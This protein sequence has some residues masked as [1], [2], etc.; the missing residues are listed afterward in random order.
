[1]INMLS[2]L[3]AQNHMLLVVFPRDSALS[4]G[5]VK[6]FQ[7]IISGA[8]LQETGMT[9]APGSLQME[10]AGSRQHY[11]PTTLQVK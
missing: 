7:K 4:Q 11:Y 5:T 1:M 10:I 8:K 9:W 6:Q 3:T 2:G